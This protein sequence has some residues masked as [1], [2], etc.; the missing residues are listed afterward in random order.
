[1]GLV[2][3]AHGLPQPVL[4]QAGNGLSARTAKHAPQDLGFDGGVVESL[5][6]LRVAPGA[7]IQE[8]L[9]AARLVRIARVVQQHPPDPVVVVGRPG[10]ELLEGHPRRHA[11][12]VADR[13]LAIGRSSDFGPVIG[14]VVVQRPDQSF[15]VG[16]AGQHGGERLGHRERAHRHTGLAVVLVA[17]GH[18][19]TVL[20][21]EQAGGLR[22][23]HVVVYRLAQ[24]AP[25][26]ADGWRLGVVGQRPG[27]SGGL[28]KLAGL[29]DLTSRPGAHTA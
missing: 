22:G 15:V 6:L 23:I 13:C 4:C 12:Q 29:R 1:M 27:L 9:D 28:D 26:P 3:S 14:G 5:A 25:A 18:H 16:N 11:E 7:G 2:F 8:F 19:L 10:V 20:E 21:D 24:K 17:L